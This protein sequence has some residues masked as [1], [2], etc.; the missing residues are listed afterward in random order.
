MKN[1][2]CEHNFPSYE[3]CPL[4]I[5]DFQTNFHIPDPDYKGLSVKEMITKMNEEERDMVNQPPHYK[6]GGVETIDY[7]EAKLTSEQFEGY[8]VGNALK[9]VSRAG[10]KG[11]AADDYR[12]AI[13]YLER[14]ANL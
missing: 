14:A 10:H 8:C 2:P 6:V 12:K 5:A 1:K 9:Y 11:K 3:P 4:C 13:W 7:I